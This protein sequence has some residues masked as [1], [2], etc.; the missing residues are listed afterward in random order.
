[1]DARDLFLIEHARVH[2]AAVAPAG[3]PLWL[4]DA[5]LRGLS[6]D[7]LRW[8]TDGGNSLAWLLWHM[9]RIEDVAVNVVLAAGGQ[10]LAEE[11]WRGR[12]VQNQATS[13]VMVRWGSCSQS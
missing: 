10:V 1:M 4:E 11:D 5:L 13:S 9:A 3:G 7:Q 12:L 8:R 2:S 6:D